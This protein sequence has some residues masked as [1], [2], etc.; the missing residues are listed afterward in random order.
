M[1]FTYQAYER[2][3]YM[4]LDAGYEITGYQSFTAVN[5]PCILR[6][7]VDVSL[8]KAL[9]FAQVEASILS[10]ENVKSTFFV[11]IT[12][13]FYNVFS[14]RS[15]RLL[16]GILNCG[17]K[18]GLHFDE[19]R[20]K[21]G[22]IRVHIET[23]AAVL[24]HIVGEKIRVVSMHR[25]SKM[26]LDKDLHLDSMINSYSHEFF[27]N[28]KYVSDS[29]MYWKENIEKVIQSREY[30]CLHLLTHPIWYDENDGGIRERILAFLNSA[31]RDRYDFLS[32]NF[33]DLHEFVK[34]SE[35]E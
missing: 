7:D 16:E 27:K 24:E 33:R 23:E 5:Q 32:E 15:C 18:I 14:S 17:H 30:P 3:I 28:F 13:D 2:L 9:E 10:G 26:M 34:R 31:N 6:H 20:Y 25:P 19:T 35:V 4:I 29:R 11:L 8:E 21:D 1:E 22:D 12:S